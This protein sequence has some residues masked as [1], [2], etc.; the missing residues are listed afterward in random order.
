MNAQ[1][2]ELFPELTPY[3]T[4]FYQTID[5]HNIYFEASGNPNGYPVV[6]LHGGPGSGCNPGQ[7]RFFDP[8]FYQIILIDQRGCGRSKPQGDTANNTTSLLVEDLEG[9]RQL[10]GHSQ[11][12]VFGGS[13]GSTLALSYAIKHPA[14]TSGLILR[15]IFLA[16]AAEMEWFLG[17]IKRFFPDVWE[18]LLSHLKPEQQNDVLKA[19][20]NLIF[21]DDIDISYAAAKAWNA[22]ESAIMRLIPNP[23]DPNNTDKAPDD[24]TKAI[25][26]AR[27]RIQLHYINN[28]CF[29]NGQ[30]I[31]K[32][33]EQ[34]SMPTWI[35]QGRY[36]MVC[37]PQ[38][39]YALKQAMPH[40][41][42]KMIA[43]A[44]HSAMEPGVISALISATEAF[45]S[46]QS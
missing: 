36:D 45:K 40:A 8:D 32:S 14:Q 39:A 21:S 34:L 31:L 5:G 44:G 3:M 41:D 38:T 37:P 43:D 6:F 15:G 12:L 33:C 18:T 7:R 35:T 16:R 25:E 20:N 27:A 4:D 24:N 2:Y 29:I 13:W 19:F 28:D 11:W 23:P 1:H 46:Q 10:L 9:I 42:F 22:Y 26:L 17:E 30:D